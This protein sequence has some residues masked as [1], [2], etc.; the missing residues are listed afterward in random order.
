[1]KSIKSL[2]KTSIFLI[3]VI[4]INLAVLSIADYTLWSMQSI[5]KKTDSVSEKGAIN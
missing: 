5:A 4:F 2:R 1:M 3:S